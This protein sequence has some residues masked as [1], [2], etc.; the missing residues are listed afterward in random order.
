M[1]AVFLFEATKLKEHPEIITQRLVLRGPRASDRANFVRLM[2]DPLVMKYIAPKPLT[3][4]ES[5]SKLLLKAGTWGLLGLGN[6]IVFHRETG[7]FLGEIGFFDAVRDTTEDLAGAFEAGWSYVP[8]TWGQGIATEAA[9]AAHKWFDE[10]H[11]G[12]RTFCIINEQ[13]TASLRVAEKCGYRLLRS[14]EDERGTQRLMS[15]QR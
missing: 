10:T 11:K 14:Y 3:E 4:A 15:R 1:S 8:D 9:I 7:D 6:W 12:Q 13:N 2:G 5:W